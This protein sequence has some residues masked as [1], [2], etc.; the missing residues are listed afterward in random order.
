VVPL[1]PK[2]RGQVAEF[3]NQCSL[4]RLGI[5]YL[6]TCVGF[7]YGLRWC[8][9][10]TFLDGQGAS[11]SPQTG[12]RSC[13]RLPARRI[14]LPGALHTSPRSTNAWV[15][16]PFRVIPSLTRQPRSPAPASHQPAG[17]ASRA[18]Q[19]D[20]SQP[21]PAAV[22]PGRGRTSGGT[23]ISTRRPSTTPRGLAL[24]PDSPWADEPSPGTLGH[25]AD[26]F[27]TRHALLMPAFALDRRPRLAHAAASPA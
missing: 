13:L 17:P 16:L 8:S 21:V 23:G 26:G 18:D 4:D 9:L 24:G 5:L 1:L 27:L 20:N 2:L 3:L 6:P 14:C 7:G 15:G 12:S 25:P 10:E 11:T 22:W 19:P